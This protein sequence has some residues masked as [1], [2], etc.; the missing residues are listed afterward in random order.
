MENIKKS[1][2]SYTAASHATHQNVTQFFT[3]AFNKARVFTRT[4][5]TR[6]NPE[7]NVFSIPAPIWEALKKICIPFK[8]EMF[9][10]HFD[11]KSKNAYQ[12]QRAFFDEVYFS[13]HREILISSF[14]LELKSKMDFLK[15]HILIEDENI[16]DE[17]DSFVGYVTGKVIVDYVS[18]YQQ[19]LLTGNLQLV[20]KTMP[21]LT[22]TI[23]DIS[24]VEFK[25]IEKNF[26]HSHYSDLISTAISRSIS[27]SIDRYLKQSRA[28]IANVKDTIY[29]EMVHYIKCEN[30]YQDQRNYRVSIGILADLANS[31]FSPSSDDLTVF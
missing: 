5:G 8:Q 14:E 28:N 25:L 17:I 21:N 31:F 9:D 1:L 11:I 13:Y 27:R 18:F 10:F 2:Y 23:Q 19:A 7:E 4:K 20:E 15:D 3:Q 12:Y 22:K 6:D 29:S 16:L 26:P 30:G 24:R